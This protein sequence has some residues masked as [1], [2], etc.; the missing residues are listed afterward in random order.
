MG[1]ILGNAGGNPGKGGIL[2]PPSAGFHGAPSPHQTWS[3]IPT[4]SRGKGAIP[5]PREALCLGPVSE[6]CWTRV[7]RT[8]E[9]LQGIDSF[10]GS[11][12]VWGM[13]AELGTGWGWVGDWGLG[14]PSWW[15]G[16]AEGGC[17]PSGELAGFLPLA[18]SHHALSL[19]RSQQP[20]RRKEDV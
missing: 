15:F 11:W 8:E 20:H 19:R 6:R 14:A 4:I 16:G 17:L 18:P 7:P 5:G 12:A 9:K 1:I 3:N 10:R 2:P 13:G